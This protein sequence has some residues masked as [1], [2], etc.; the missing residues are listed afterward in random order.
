[1]NRNRQTEILGG[2]LT[3]VILILLIFLSN[4]ETNKLSFLESAVSSVVNPIQRVITDLKNKIQGNQSYFSNMESII[5]E[6]EELKEKNSEL[7]T[8]LREMELIKAENATLRSYNNMKQEYSEYTTVPGYIINKDISN[9]SNTMIINV[10]TDDGID[11]NMPVIT[12]EGLVGYTIAVTNKT[13]KVQPIIDP[14]TSVSSA[15][16][17]SRDS[18]IVKG[19]LRKYEYFETYVYSN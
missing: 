7:E 15:I 16:S 14:A 4:V 11:V 17:T 2:I 8:Q 1:M 19:I 6:N 10:G 3:V 12:T 18:V 5:A 13:A 9:L